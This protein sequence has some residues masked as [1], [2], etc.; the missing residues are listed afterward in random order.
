GSPAKTNGLTSSSPPSLMLKT[1]HHVRTRVSVP[2]IRDHRSRLQFRQTHEYSSRLF[3]RAWLQQLPTRHRALEKRLEE[4]QRSRYRQRPSQL[5]L[6][7]PD[8]ETRL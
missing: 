7:E 1:P 6:R 3:R 8:R 4:K 5:A 2:V